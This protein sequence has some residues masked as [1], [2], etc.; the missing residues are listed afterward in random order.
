LGLDNFVAVESHQCC[1]V[2]FLVLRLR[3]LPYFFVF[4]FCYL[5]CF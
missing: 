4:N 2:L 1:L 5:V 3:N